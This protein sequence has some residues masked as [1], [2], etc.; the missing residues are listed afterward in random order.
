MKLVARVFISREAAMLGEGSV[1]HF[2]WTFQF[3][4]TSRGILLEQNS[5]QALRLSMSV[6]MHD[7][8]KNLL[9]FSSKLVSSFSSFLSFLWCGRRPLV[10]GVERGRCLTG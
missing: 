9:F 5:C 3:I 1:H 6:S 8:G 7:Y 4:N 10:L 2:I